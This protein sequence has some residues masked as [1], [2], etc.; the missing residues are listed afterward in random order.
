MTT[1]EDVCKEVLKQLIPTKKE[2]EETEKMFEAIAKFIKEK[3][4]IQA[5]LMGSSARG[6]DMRGDKDI[7]TFIFFPTTVSR[8]ELEKR[9]LEIGK[10]VFEQFKGTYV[11]DYA[12]HPYTKGIIKGFRVEVVPAYDIKDIDHRYTAVDRTPFHN[13]YV[14]RNLKPAQRN[15]VRLLKK[16]LDGVGCYGSDLKTQGFSGYLC[17]LL[18]LKHGNFENV[19]RAMQK[20]EFQQIID[21]ENY[22][23][24][25]DEFKVKRMFENQPLIVIDPVDK[26]RNVAAV[27][28]KERLARAIFHARQFLT[29]SN[30]EFFYPKCA[31][32]EKGK[33]MTLVKER[34]TTIVAITFKKPK[35]IEDILYP[36]LRK[37][38]RALVKALKEEDFSVMDSW[39][40]GDDECGVGLELLSTN[41]PKY[42]IIYGPPI[43]SSPQHQEAFVKKYK[44]VWFI[45]ERF[46][47][48]VERSCRELNCF[49]VGWLS[50]DAEQLQLKGIPSSIAESIEKGFKFMENISQ[51]KSE[52]FWRGLEKERIK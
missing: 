8:E 45:E 22:Y 30:V 12:E 21:I 9:A 29:D 52:E 20:F 27:L 4:A 14:K 41:L 43:F 3:F 6:T 2:A 31:K 23:S 18:V 40:F 5:R 19:L 11:I 32:C 35:I 39:V 47:A 15:E 37:F 49:L 1:V 38:E 50:G 28:S 33:L 25:G 17:E 51:I 44:K 34:N 16:F 26:N 7:D 24:E 36:Q 13:E 48:E 42:K 10:R 46:V